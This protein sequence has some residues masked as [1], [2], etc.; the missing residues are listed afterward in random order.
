MWEGSLSALKLSDDP[1]LPY[2]V[3]NWMFPTNSMTHDSDGLA[4]SVGS[5]V[6]PPLIWE[7]SVPFPVTVFV[8]LSVNS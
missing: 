2:D 4:H 3:I 7:V 8:Q 6:S 5:M 1:D